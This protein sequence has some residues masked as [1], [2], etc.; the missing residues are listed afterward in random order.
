VSLAITLGATVFAA[1]SAAR[2]EE[3]P[4][5][6]DGVALSRFEPSERGSRF[7]L[8]DSLELRPHGAA[9]AGSLLSTG[10]ASSWAWRAATYGTRAEGERSRLV[11]HA[12][13]LHPGASIVLPPGARFALDVPVVAFQSGED[14]SL[15]G[16]LHPAPPSPALGDI[17]ASFDLYLGRFALGRT[18][19]DGVTLAGG[20][21]AWLPTGAV[22]AFAG[23]IGARFG[24]QIASTLRL[25]W[26]LA[27]TR[28][29]YMYRRDGWLGG[30]FVG[31]EAGVTGGVAWTDRV[32]TIGPEIRAS[33][34]LDAAF[35]LRTT[36]VEVLV[37]ARRAFGPFRVGAGVGT[38]I[39]PGMGAAR[40]RGV[41]SIEWAPEVA[42]SDR[43]RDGVPDEEDVCPD[44]AGS[45]DGSLV[46]ARGCPVGPQDRDRDGIPDVDDACPDVF[47]VRTRDRRTHG[48][49]PPEPALD[50]PAAPVP[51]SPAAPVPDSPAA[52]V[53]DSPAAPVPDSPAAPA[54]LPVPES[55]PTPA[56]PPDAVSG[57]ASA[58]TSPRPWLDDPGCGAPSLL[59]LPRMARRSVPAH[60][61]HC[62][63]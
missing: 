54:P 13:Y 29:H 53:P 34:V 39:S 43:D 6:L 51:D 63:L 24:A 38:A 21:S 46:G 37:G 16:R 56:P 25:S 15:S 45:A 9:P 47:G 3:P 28:V 48:C 49:P 19:G 2:A 5:V 33:T 10:I 57:G 50:S 1:S 14:T 52:P 59:L 18:A 12:I 42:V 27:A 36:P 4:P 31:P 60:M 26:L 58:G 23:D 44:V 40:L 30:S 32:W 55:P 62:V 8:A 17:R 20:V 41:L 22:T 7:F 61:V 11:G 35:A